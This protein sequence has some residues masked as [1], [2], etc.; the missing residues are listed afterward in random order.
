MKHEAMNKVISHISSM[1]PWELHVM[2]VELV[3]KVKL[4]FEQDIKNFIE[5]DVAEGLVDCLIGA[6]NLRYSL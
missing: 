1:D 5:K 6:N 2:F 3:A 4:V